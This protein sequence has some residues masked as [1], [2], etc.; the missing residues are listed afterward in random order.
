MW[1]D[2]TSISK[3][4]PSVSGETETPS[5]IRCLGTKN[6]NAQ[7]KLA[8]KVLCDYSPRAMLIAALQGIA[9][10]FGIGEI[11]AVCATRQRSYTEECSAIFK[12][13]CDDFFTKLGMVKTVTGFYSSPIPIKGKPLASFNGRARFG[14]RA[15]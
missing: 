6:C 13:G 11:E 9:D 1:S 15:I 12:K 2:T 14:Y 4:I 3:S 7:I 8:R 10:A 5:V